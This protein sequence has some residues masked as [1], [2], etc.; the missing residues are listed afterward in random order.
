MTVCIS[1][2]GEGALPLGKIDTQL[3][4]EEVLKLMA[5]RVAA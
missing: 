5:T 2:G 3:V 4:E 1:N